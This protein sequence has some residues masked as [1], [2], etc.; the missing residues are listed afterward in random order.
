MRERVRP[1]TLEEAAK[2][3]LIR[4]APLLRRLPRHVDRLATSLERGTLRGRL[5]LFSD[6]QDVRVVTRLVN[7]FVLALMGGS[8]GVIGVFLLNAEGSPP[9]AGETTLYEFFGHFSLFCSIV[10]IMRVIV[11]ILHDGLN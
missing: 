2:S 11:A 5:S 9:F 3:E 6:E 10:L 4:M 1:G 7:R 8:V